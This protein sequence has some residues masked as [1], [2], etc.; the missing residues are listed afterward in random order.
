[1]AR[2]PGKQTGRSLRQFVALWDTSIVLVLVMEDYVKLQCS[3]R[4]IVACRQTIS[5]DGSD[6]LCW[7]GGSDAFLLW[8]QEFRNCWVGIC[9]RLRVSEAR[10][11]L[12]A[13]DILRSSS[14]SRSRSI[15]VQSQSQSQ[16]QS[17]TQTLPQSKHQT[18][19]QPRP[20][21]TNDG[22]EPDCSRWK[23]PSFCDSLRKDECGRNYIKKGA[24]VY[25]V[26]RV[27]VEAQIDRH[28]PCVRNNMNK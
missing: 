15:S 17:R 27:L 13:H 7:S 8:N 21:Y 11:T 2:S 9:W 28:C 22:Q 24:E 20:Q 1:M 10:G 16:T 12:C 14:R 26:G 5:A 25:K 19:P 6:E 23:Q 3:K 18:Q 4:R